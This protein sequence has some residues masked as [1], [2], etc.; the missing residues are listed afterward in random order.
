MPTVVSADDR[1]AVVG[2]G[3][4]PNHRLDRLGRST[5]HLITLGA[6]LRERGIGLKGDHQDVVGAEPRQHQIELRA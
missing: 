3:M 6:D 4:E 1:S 2:I 5:L